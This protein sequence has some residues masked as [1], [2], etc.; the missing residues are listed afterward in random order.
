MKRQEYKLLQKGLQSRLSED[1]LRKLND[2]GFIWEAL[3]GGPRRQKSVREVVPMEPRASNTVSKAHRSKGGRRHHSD[4]SSGSQSEGE[5]ESSSQSERERPT[6]RHKSPTG[7][8][9]HRHHRRDRERES[10]HHKHGSGRKDGQAALRSAASGLMAMVTSPN[11][12]QGAIPGEVAVAAP[13]Q[14][15]ETQAYRLFEPSD[16]MPGQMAYPAMYPGLAVTGL[17]WGHVPMAAVGGIP[18][19]IP[20]ERLHMFGVPPHLAPTAHDPSVAPSLEGRPSDALPAGSLSRTK[21]PK[22]G[23]GVATEGQDKPPNQKASALS[24]SSRGSAVAPGAPTGSRQPMPMMPPGME[25][26]AHP[27]LP[28]EALTAPYFHGAGPIVALHP[29]FV[30]GHY[31]YGYPFGMGLYRAP[32]H[33]MPPGP[34]SDSAIRPQNQSDDDDEEEDDE[35]EEQGEPQRRG[36]KNM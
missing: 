7:S 13:G 32:P 24:L 6:K 27:Y 16:A 23:S 30:M 12:S 29:Q 1:R 14:K 31:P 33:F 35:E 22:I 18:T 9:R 36:G 20:L 17:G 15:A 10:K 21:Q 5:S 2:V 4:D 3:R 26:A 34:Q 28:R 8:H 11:S 25:L 19:G